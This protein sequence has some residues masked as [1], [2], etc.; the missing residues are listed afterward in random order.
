M[1]RVC[2]FCGSRAGRQSQ[3]AR[4]ARDLAQ[5]LSDRSLD[6][7]YGGGSVGLMGILADT[8][9]SRGR[10]VIGVIPKQLATSELMHT[11]VADMR[12]VH[13][14]HERKALMLELA[15]VFVTLPGGFGSMEELFE[16][17]SWRQLG[18]HPHPVGVLNVDGYYDSLI[19]LADTMLA[20][21]FVTDSTRE[22]MIVEST[23]AALMDRLENSLSTEPP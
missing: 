1:K 15:D 14:M 10:R 23:V 4:A 12:I 3:F 22:L 11:E 18:L 20:Q 16:V 5:E 19:G 7:V 9:L 2:V 13:S 8:M 21:G 6:L 17:L